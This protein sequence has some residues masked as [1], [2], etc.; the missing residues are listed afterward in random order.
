M[1]TEQLSGS[2]QISNKLKDRFVSCWV[3]EPIQTGAEELRELDVA[4]FIPD[5]HGAPVRLT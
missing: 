3:Y 2:E 4:V 5:E 1:E